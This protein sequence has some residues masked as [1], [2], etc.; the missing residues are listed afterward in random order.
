MSYTLSDKRGMYRRGGRRD[1][2]EYPLNF[3]ELLGLGSLSLLATFFGSIG[4]IC[5]STWWRLSENFAFSPP[6]DK[7]VAAYWRGIQ[8]SAGLGAILF[9]IATLAVILIGGTAIWRIMHETE[10]ED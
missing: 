10:H 8:F 1:M 3:I 9:Y 6:P 7:V 4:A 5:L 2:K